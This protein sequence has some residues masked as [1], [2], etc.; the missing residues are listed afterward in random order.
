MDREV[1]HLCILLRLSLGFDVGDKAIED[2]KNVTNWDAIIKLAARQNVSALAYN[3]CLELPFEL[4]PF[5]TQKINWG[6]NAEAIKKK[7]LYHLSVV[8]SLSEFFN[9]HNIKMILLKGRGL[10]MFYPDP[11]LRQEDDI[12][13]YLSGAFNEGNRLLKEQGIL[14]NTQYPKHA[15][16]KYQ[17]RM[18]ENHAYFLDKF[19]GKELLIE[20]YLSDCLKGEHT[21]LKVQNKNILLPP[22]Q[23]NTVFLMKHALNHLWRTETSLRH[24][25]DW[26]CFLK[27]NY[28]NIDFALYRNLMKKVGLLHLADAFTALTVEVLHLPKHFVPPFKRD[29]RT[30]LRMMNKI[31]RKP[32]IFE[33]NS[34]WSKLNYQ[35]KKNIEQQDIYNLYFSKSIWYRIRHKI[36]RNI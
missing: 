3:G 28:G 23:F 22:P 26:A 1:Q 17:G 16:F 20:C 24:I 25:C 7:N 5:R 21:S 13:I 19:N 34:V 6:L 35:F 8:V 30:E 32:L 18:V 36:V 2:F 15:K 29:F 9:K 11:L 27:N 10:A 4:Q 14:V 31:L 12:D 33:G